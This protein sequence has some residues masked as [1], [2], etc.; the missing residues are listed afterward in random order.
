[1]FRRHSL[2]FGALLLAACG[3]DRDANDAPGVLSLMRDSLPLL[4]ATA[5]ASRCPADSTIA[6]VALGPAWT[7]ALSMR[8]AWPADTARE[9]PVA[10]T[11]GAMATAVVAA[12][13][14]AD[15]IGP[16]LVAGRGTVH[17]AAGA[18]LSGWFEAMAATQPGAPDSVRLEGHFDGVTVNDDLCPTPRP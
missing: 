16:A 3:R 14:V 4:S 1:M 6:V 9:L 2:A 11:A 5:T 17:L 13:P 8:V 7:A 10:A 15:S 18:P 12:R